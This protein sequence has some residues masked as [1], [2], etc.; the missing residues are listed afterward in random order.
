MQTAETDNFVELHQLIDRE[1]YDFYRQHRSH[2]APAI[3]QY[4]Y[5]E[6]AVGGMLKSL[7]R[8]TVSTNGGVDIKGLGYFCHIKSK[9][10]RKKPLEKNPLKKHI[11]HNRYYFWFYPEEG[12]REWYLEPIVAVTHKKLKEYFVIPESAEM[13]YSMESYSNSL[14]HKSKEIKYLK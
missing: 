14:R 7:K 5:F 1:F 2:C 12:I 3:D 8:L 6:R 9:T 11:K 4:N 13:R 10:K